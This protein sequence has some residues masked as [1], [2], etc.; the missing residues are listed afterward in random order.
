MQGNDLANTP[1][2]RIVLVAEGAL[3]FCDESNQKKSERAM[4]RRRWAEALS[5]WYIN[6]LMA[7]RLWDIA[8]SA[9]I[10]LD[11]VTFLGPDDF[12]EE[13]TRWLAHEELP[14]RSVF[15]S[16]PAILSRMATFRKDIIRVYTPFPDQ[17]LR[18]GPKG[19]V[20]TDVNQVGRD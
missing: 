4:E 13:L 8:L 5:Y 3:M 18:Y 1:A 10:N 9:D 17:A 20:L 6:D 14:V 19:V 2:P 12:A 7:N 16:T 15:A 11:V